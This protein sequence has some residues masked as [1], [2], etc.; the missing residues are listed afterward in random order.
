MDNMKWN[1][2]KMVPDMWLWQILSFMNAITVKFVFKNHCF[3]L[4]SVWKIEAFHAICSII[5]Q[6]IINN[7]KYHKGVSTYYTT[8]VSIFTVYTLS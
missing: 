1:S 8:D 4:L 3:Q 7:M 2:V 5:K 6:I